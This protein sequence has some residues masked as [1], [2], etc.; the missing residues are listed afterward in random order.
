MSR[1]PALTLLLVPFLSG[2]AMF[3]SSDTWPQFRGP[4]GSASVP[5]QRIPDRFGPEENLIWKSVVPAGNSSPAIWGNHIYLTGYEGEVHQ[6]LCLQRSDG[7]VVWV[8]EFPVRT[9]EDYLHRDSSPAA[10]TICVD[11]KRVYAYFG[12][13]GLIALDHDGNRVWE[14]EFPAESWSFGAG[15]SPILDGDALYLVRDTAGLSAVYCFDAATGK[16]RWMMPR[17]DAFQNYASPYIWH[18]EDH[19]ELVVGGSGKLR[20][21]DTGTGEELWVVTNLPAFI[22]PSPVA[23]SGLLIFGGWTTANIPGAEKIGTFFDLDATFPE[24]HSR[25]PQRFVEYFDSGGDGRIQ[26]SEL[27]ESRVRDA[28]RYLDRNRNGALEVEKVGAE[29]NSGAAPGRNVLVAVRAGGRGDITETHIVWEKTKAL[30]YVASPTIHDGRVYY[31]KKGGFISCLDVSSG[32]PHYQERLGLGGEYYATPVGVGDRIIVAA[33]RGAVFVLSN[34][35]TF[36]VVARNELGEGMYAT[37]AVVDNTL[38]IRTSDHLWAF[39]E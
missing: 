9:K 21:Y 10:P 24:E 33:E 26:E 17:P 22:C 13:Y 19:S 25:D 8:K 23:T 1:M 4:G 5:N 7:Q 34:S 27:P 36:E 16:E 39:G 15:A 29:M 12:A 14:R 37:P 18:H 28:F 20:G 35:D 31:L 30:P 6:V 2:C 3:A 32:E 38:Y 11:A